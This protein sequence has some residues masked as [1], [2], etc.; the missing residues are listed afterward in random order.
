[1]TPSGRGAAVLFAGFA[2]W[3][4]ARIVGSPGLEVIG[5]GLVSLPI[6]AALFIRWGRQRIAVRR[7]LSDVRVTPGTR[8][9]VQIEVENRAPTPT[10]FLMLED[11]LP[12]ALGRRARLVVAGI[13]GRG[14]QKVSYTVLPQ[15]RGRYQLGPLVVDVSDPF[16]LIR[17]R[18]EFNEREELLVTPEIEDLSTGPDSASGPTAGASR[19]RNLFR[20]GEEYYTMRQYQEGDDLRRIHW[21]S[22]ARTGSLM[23][24]QDESSRRASGVVFLDTRE[25]GLGRSRG[26]GFERAVSVAATLGSMLARGG[27][28]LRLATADAQPA[29]FS[30]DRFLEVL[31]GVSHAAVRSLGPS[32]ANLRANA[33]GDT[34]FIYVGAPTLPGETTSVIRSGGAYGAKLAVFVY[35]VDPDTLPPE[36][37][38][39][40]EGR[41]TQARLA[42]IRAGWDCI[43]LPPSAQ[44]K[45]RWHTPR[46]RLLVHSG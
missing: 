36:R 9:T 8:V 17:Q 42:L 29:A 39:Q 3:L 20:S 19:T 12:P 26:P 16:A 1:M 32:L 34:T 45:D 25:G 2:M 46:E 41:A 40:L 31:A 15:V 11:R 4:T 37:Q 22:V 7:R 6:I 38:A 10:S 35:P 30:E 28:S 5:I 21:P 24:R 14:T 27:F 13:H 44:L 43:V 18:L 23:I 33:S